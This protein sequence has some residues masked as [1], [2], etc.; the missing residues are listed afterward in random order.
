VSYQIQDKCFLLLCRENGNVFIAP[1][2]YHADLG[3]PDTGTPQPA[4]TWDTN[5]ATITNFD[6]GGQYFLLFYKV[7]GPVF[8]APILPSGTA[9]A[10]GTDLKVKWE[11]D[12]AH[13][14]QVQ[15]RQ[16]IG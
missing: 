5:W 10:K 4:G 13:I 12:W 3:A 2:T 11:N 6:L 8:T 16:K 7:D 1:V 15:Y 14:L 9:V